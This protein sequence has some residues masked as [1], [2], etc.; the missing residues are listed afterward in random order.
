MV[1]IAIDVGGTFTDC[2]VL[3][4]RGHLGQFKS[5]TTPD[6]PSRGFMNSLEKAA[7]HAAKDPRDFI[8]EVDVIIHGTTLATNAL[9]TERGAKLGMLTTEGFRDELEIRRGFKNIR[10]S[11]YNLAVPPYKPL[12]RRYLRLPVRERTLYSGAIE[13]PVELSSVS[14]ALDK[15]EAEGVQA[16]AVCF[17]HSYANPENERKAAQMCRDRFG[18]RVYI[19][20]SHDILPVSGEYERFSTTVVSAYIGPIVS[21]YLLALEDRLTE[22]GFTGNLLMVSSDALVQSAAHSRRQAVTLINS[23]PA[24]APT[25]AHFFGRLLGHEDL[26]SIDMG[27]T[28]LDAS[29]IRHG[30]IPTTTESWV[31][32]ERVAIKIIETHSI[33]AGGGSL[34]WID[35]LGLLRVGPQSA[36]SAPGPACYGRG[37]EKPT[38]TDADVLLGYVPADYFL[39]GEIKLDAERARRAILTIAEPLK[40]TESEAAQAIFRIVNSL[41]ADQVIEMSTKRGYDVR[42]FA[43]IVGGGAGGV[44]GAYIAD[45]LGIPRVIIPKYAALYSAFGMFAMDMGREYSQSCLVRADKL[46][47]E[48]LEDLYGELAEKATADLKESHVDESEPV[49]TRTAQIRYVG[50]FHDIEVA[51]PGTLRSPED[52]RQVVETFHARHKELYKFDLPARAIEFRTCSLRAT[53]AR[54]LD[55]KLMPLAQG[56]IDPGAAWKRMRRCLFGGDWIDTPC[57][58]GQR[59]FAGN[60]I[61]GPAIIEE[62][63]TTIVVP[64]GFDCAVDTSGSYLLTRR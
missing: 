59:L 53:L 9:L 64:D 46:D 17:L 45:L 41:M 8:G 63:A 16:I 56:Q 60:V 19:A 42:D 30:E 1:S 33:G 39:G 61:P 22:M 11:M 5:P 6:D 13:T 14:A 37:G 31:G 25:A 55:L 32:D 38:V 50:Q 20:T 12:V 43:L 35:S 57:Y 34:A 24:A 26:I 47:P 58:D 29:L 49:S 7:R 51:L 21:D 18:D 23:G 3:D 36:G 27:G 54:K 2:L 52:I 40:M 15:F 48:R 62:E 44:H 10:T 28:S 4:G